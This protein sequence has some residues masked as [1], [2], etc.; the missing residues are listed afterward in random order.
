MIVLSTGSSL[1]A[2]W[3]NTTIGQRNVAKTITRLKRDWK[4]CR[5]ILYQQTIFIIYLLYRS[6]FAKTFVL[7]AHWRHD[8]LIFFLN[9]SISCAIIVAKIKQFFY[10][11]FFQQIFYSRVALVLFLLRPLKVYG[12]LRKRVTKSWILHPLLDFLAPSA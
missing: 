3:I 6:Y 8:T 4:F 10:F 7:I 11:L 12:Q 1:F 9:V 2:V 5:V